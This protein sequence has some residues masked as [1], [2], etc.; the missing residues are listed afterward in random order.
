MAAQVH[1]YY[2]VT[3]ILA[4][5]DPRDLS[6][7]VEDA[8]RLVAFRARLIARKLLALRI[9]QWD[10]ERAEVSQRAWKDAVMALNADQD[11]PY[12]RNGFKLLCT[13]LRF[14]EVLA[15]FDRKMAEHLL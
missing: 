6:A 4:V 14:P 3:Q 11:V 8:E 10:L 2:V 12:M 7:M 1:V 5:Q 15:V 13:C 9:E